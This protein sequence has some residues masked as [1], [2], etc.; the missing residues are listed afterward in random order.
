MTTSPGKTKILAV[1]DHEINIRLLSTYLGNAGFDVIPAYDGNEIVGK[2]DADPDIA[3]ILLD[4]MMPQMNGIDALKG[5]KE[6][7][8]YRQIPVI[9]LTAAWSREMETEAK[10]AGAYAYL[11]KPYDKEKIFRTVWQALEEAKV[12][13]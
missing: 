12:Q 4:R 2:L 1:D 5:L 3:A 9:M 6:M 10:E 13:H 11:T 7:P 8:Q